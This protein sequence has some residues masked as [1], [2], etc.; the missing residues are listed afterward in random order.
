MK[1]S[2]VYD[3][4]TSVYLCVCF[5]DRA[6]ATPPSSVCTSEH[7]PTALDAITS[8]QAKGFAVWALETTDKSERY[9]D[10]PRT[11]PLPQQ[12]QQQQSQEHHH[13]E[14]KD[15]QELDSA[16]S[17]AAYPPKVALVMGNEVTGVAPAAL[18][19]CDRVLAIPTFGVKNSLNVAVAGSIVAYEV[20]RA[21]SVDS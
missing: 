17:S 21:W 11:S 19:Q 18:E 9:T 16:S 20:I 6:L 1:S 7:A 3:I 10:P 12:L 8:L 4:C 2:C 5:C 15:E 14:D 13:Q